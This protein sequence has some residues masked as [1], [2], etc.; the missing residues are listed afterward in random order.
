[1]KTKIIDTTHTDGVADKEFELRLD[2]IRSKI[3]NFSIRDRAIFEM[4]LITPAIEPLEIITLNVS[5]IE[6]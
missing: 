4:S 1:M 2:S 5:D 3:G 6:C